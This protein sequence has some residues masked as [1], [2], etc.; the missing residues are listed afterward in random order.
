[1]YLRRHVFAQKPLIES[2]M[3]VEHMWGRCGLSAGDDYKT[4]IVINLLFFNLVS[5]GWGGADVYILETS[6]YRVLAIQ[7]YV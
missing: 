3:L 7:R 1:M 5:Y 6:Y 4:R 2:M